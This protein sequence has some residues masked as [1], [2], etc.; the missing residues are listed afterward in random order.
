MT[1]PAIAHIKPFGLRMQP[2]LRT[3][4]EAAALN[5]GTSLN[6]VICN[7]LNKSLL[8]DGAS[9]KYKIMLAEAM[10]PLERQP[11]QEP[12]EMLGSIKRKIDLLAEVRMLKIAIKINR[13]P[14]KSKNSLNLID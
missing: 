10:V 2:D 9:D 4:I 13:L 5:Q 12:M 7:R 8:E 14:W 3:R 1:Q 6:Q 11:S